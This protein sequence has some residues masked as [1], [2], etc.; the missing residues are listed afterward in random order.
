MGDMSIESMDLMPVVKAA[1]ALSGEIVLSRLIER[2]M[3][4][5]LAHTGAERG[6]LILPQGDDL[7]IAAK[8]RVA[9]GE[10]RAVETESGSESEMDIQVEVHEPPLPP[11]TGELPESLLR[12]V[13]NT[14]EKLI[15]DNATASDRQAG[16]V[17]CLPLLRQSTLIAVL[18]LEHRKPYI[19]TPQRSAALEL[20]ATQAA[21]SLENATS[22]AELLGEY[23]ENRRLGKTLIL[24]RARC[25]AILDSALEA[26][27]TIDAEQR[28]VFFNGA[29][30]RMFGWPAAQ[31]I[32]EPLQRLI[33]ARFH[34]AHRQHVERFV[35]SGVSRRLMG[36]TLAVFGVRANG[37][38]FPVDAAIS[39]VDCGGQK[40]LTAMLRDNTERQ[41]LDHELRQYREH[42]EELVA[43]RTAELTTLKEHLATDLADLK[44]LHEL[45]TR[46]LVEKENAP[47]LQEVLAAAMELLGANKGKLQLYDEKHNVLRIV[48]QIGFSQAFVD[49]FSIVPPF[50]AICGTAMGTHR[51]EIVENV[52][53]D[54]R[55]ADERELYLANDVLAMQSTP[56][57]GSDGLLYGVLT[58]HSRMPGR[59]SERQLR[60]LDLYAQQATRVIESSERATQLGLAKQQA[61]E[62]D[63]LK[64]AFLTGM[65]HELRTPLNAILGYTQILARDPGLNERQVDGLNTIRQSGEHLLTLINDILDLSKI[66]AGRFELS[67]EPV[68]LP[69]F[70]QVV[71]EIIAIKA[72]QKGLR[73]ALE[74]APDLPAAVR[75]DQRRLRQVLLNLLGNAVKFTEHGQVILRIRCL[76]RDAAQARLLFEIE[77][78][79]IGIAADRLEIIYQP[80]EQ[81]GGAQQRAGGTGLGLTISRQLMRMMDSDLHVESQPAQGSRFWFELTLPL[82]GEREVKKPVPVR[83]VTGYLGQHRKLLIADDEKVNRKMLAEL[84]RSLGFEIF[85][86]GNGRDAVALAQAER[87]DLILMDVK[88]PLMEGPEAIR[89]L[90]ALPGFDTLP[91]LASSASESAARSLAAGASDFIVKPID[92]QLL[93][94]LIGRHLK[95]TW[96]EAPLA[97]ASNEGP[98]LA[99]PPEEMKFLRQLALTG[100][101]R[102][103]KKRGDYLTALDVRYAPFADRLRDLARRYQSQAI[104]ALVNQY[105]KEPDS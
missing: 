74:A 73:F 55:F 79:G 93:L 96:I 69:L 38:E 94:D 48:A 58:T 37:Q 57:Y 44:R 97:P 25:T 82:S 35:E 33:P 62:A 20:L 70:L 72:E 12:Q 65:S 103:L 47:L 5:A 80:F 87:P 95:L 51:R 30:E 81:L 100:N 85:E 34:V 14:R 89:Q 3:R 41:R 2:L 63:R 92:Q 91:V 104:L 43:K 84:L 24:G 22:Y 71:T 1:Q 13:A 45:S 67:P 68:S 101:M 105:M 99:P 102:D 21:I 16:S 6:L 31:M 15:L 75:V 18:Y 86:A 11:E 49:K 26:I 52:L 4:V 59:P 50:F 39:Q 64:S 23:E 53:T 40:L 54:Q 98:L 29:A 8:A 32:G 76:S 77:D 10:P 42:L 56:L 78:S 90:R 28:I 61:E 83:V 19:F 9:A 46:L 17:L 88:M 60:L 66:E 7:R 27:V 36:M